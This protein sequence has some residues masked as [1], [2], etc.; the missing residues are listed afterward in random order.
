MTISCSNNKALSVY[1][2]LLS[3]FLWRNAWASSPL[4]Q[5]AGCM[6]SLA[7]HE[8]ILR[9][10]RCNSSGSISS[11]MAFV[12]P[13]LLSSSGSFLSSFHSSSCTP[14][15]ATVKK[16]PLRAKS[17][18]KKNTEVF[19]ADRVLAQRSQR[20]RTE[21]FN[22]LKQK[23]VWQ[24]RETKEDSDAENDDSWIFVPGPSTKLGMHTR[25]WIDR[26][27]EV[28]LPPPLA[29]VF[30]KPKWV[31][32]VTSDPMG[33]PCLDKSIIPNGMHPVGRLDYDSSGLLLFSSSGALTQRLLHP[34]HE[35]P[36][37]YEVVVTDR[38]DETKLREQLTSG[39]KTGEG[40][41]TADLLSVSHFAEP[42]VAP[43]LAEVR[44]GIPSHYN[45]TDLEQRGYLD[46]F[47][48]TALS[49]VKVRVREGKYRMVR[50]IMANCGHPVVT[51]VRQ[52]F[53]DIC[54]GD[55]PE[56]KLRAVTAEQEAWLKSVLAGRSS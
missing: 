43:Y 35:I 6:K 7:R 4:R 38:V 24:R 31:L 49:T 34:K 51:L 26:T 13:W 44:A 8:S 32:S 41:H 56:G 28:P 46:I 21:C 47:Q 25:L 11:G 10:P 42:E 15:A 19:R 5:S 18:K 48:A 50:R 37:E 54:L 33:R 23:R 52:Q 22:I 3:M 20:P 36:K 9:G 55:L 29:M 45:Q 2:V 53:G 39:V 27:H 14:H 30:H 1:P 17:K 16:R 40:I 12:R